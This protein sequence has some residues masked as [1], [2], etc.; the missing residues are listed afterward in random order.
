MSQRGH[1]PPQCTAAPGDVK[2]L[3]TFSYTSDAWV[4]RLPKYPKRHTNTDDRLSE[5][6]SFFLDKHFNQIKIQTFQRI[7]LKRFKSNKD[8]TIFHQ[9]EIAFTLHKQHETSQGATETCLR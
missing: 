8:G 1:L 4:L 7:K 2:A 5:P 3:E 6:A 9:E